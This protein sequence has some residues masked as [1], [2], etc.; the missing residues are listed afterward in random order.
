MSLKKRNGGGQEVSDSGRDSTVATTQKRSSKKPKSLANTRK[1]MAAYFIK[2]WTG[3]QRHDVVTVRAIV[4]K[5]W[6]AARRAA[7]AA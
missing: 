2:H 1:E 4:D 6:A 3:A 7:R 5:A